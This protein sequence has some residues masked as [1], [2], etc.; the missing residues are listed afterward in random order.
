MSSHTAQ[1]A[2][3][4]AET[5][6]D[7]A[8]AVA[9]AVPD[10]SALADNAPKKRHQLNDVLGMHMSIARVASHLKA[11]LCD[12]ASEGRL[13]LLRDQQKEARAT[14][15]LGALGPLA[16]EI[17]EIAQK[18]I[19][20][21]S[22][23]AI[24]IAAA[25]N[26]TVEALVRD[27]YDKTLAAGRKMVEIQYIH[28][29]DAADKVWYPLFRNLPAFVSYN[30]DLEI[31]LKRQRAI[32]NKHGKEQREARKKAKE[33]GEPAPEQPPAREDEDEDEDE[34][35]TQ[36]HT[37]FQTYVDVAFK[38]IKESDLAYKHLRVA[39]RTREVTALFVKEFMQRIARLAKITVQG[40]LDVRTLNSRHVVQLIHMIVVDE[41]RPAAAEALLGF[42]E[43][44]L[45]LYRA[46]LETEKLR[47]WEELPAEKKAE[48][49][50]KKVLQSL[51]RLRAAAESSRVRAINEAHRAKKLKV[52]LTQ[53]IALAAAAVPASQ[54]E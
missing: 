45:T 47:K 40:L 30:P 44:K 11:H 1:T 3:L 29:G 26:W 52:E 35:S 42:V 41:G 18:Q 51:E 2:G 25:L 13:R 37:S 21:S 49:E 9:N 48:I 46:Y 53:L 4:L 5:L 27:V 12:V 31:L 20:V 16:A 39:G 50:A 17:N 54:A 38:K 19:R 15:D 7:P 14:H 24:A 43:G 34:E 36:V 10:E 33:N 23:T 6:Q 28:A 22:E 32:D 8:P